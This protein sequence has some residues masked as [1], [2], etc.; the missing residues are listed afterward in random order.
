MIPKGKKQIFFNLLGRLIHLRIQ[1]LTWP[2]QVPRR[3]SPACRAPSCSA[4]CSPGS[5]HAVIS[6]PQTL[7]SW[8]C[9]SLFLGCS[10]SHRWLL[11]PETSPASR[12]S[13]L[14][15]LAKQP[16][17]SSSLSRHPEF[18]QQSG[19][20]ACFLAVSLPRREGTRGGDVSL[21]FT[22]VS[23]DRGQ[24]FTSG[25]CLIWADA[26]NTRTENDTIINSLVPVA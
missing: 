18:L 2:N 15:G 19:Q 24:C 7:H 22:L 5:K 10:S 11:R 3:L 4:L 17:G 16:F 13:S 12:R 6:C 14:T 21:L 25:R 9:R 23:Q 20:L 8:P 1:P 26:M